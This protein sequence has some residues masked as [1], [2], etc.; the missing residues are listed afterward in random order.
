MNAIVEHY[1]LDKRLHLAYYGASL[2]GKEELHVTASQAFSC[3]ALFLARE[4]S[5]KMRTGD[6]VLRAKA[7]KAQQRR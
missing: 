7:T 5:C 6:T 2:T 4:L 3:T 1:F